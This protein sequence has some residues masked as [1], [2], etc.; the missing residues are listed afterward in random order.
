MKKI[1]E[2]ALL[3][4]NPV[5]VCAVLF[6]GSVCGMALMHF[7]SEFLPDPKRFS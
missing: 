1:D 7:L 5:T 4:V 6:T 2:H 3:S